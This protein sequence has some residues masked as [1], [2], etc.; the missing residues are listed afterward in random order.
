MAGGGGDSLADG[1]RLKLSAAA[2]VSRSTWRPAS[3]GRPGDGADS[4][5]AS[6][7]AHRRQPRAS[8]PP[9]RPTI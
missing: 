8:R 9:H 3:G 5:K 6:S 2:A 1:S 4:Q 7:R